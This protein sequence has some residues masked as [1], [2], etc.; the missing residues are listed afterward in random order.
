MP[1]ARGVELEIVF[2]TLNAAEAQ[3]IRSRLDAAGYQPVL[4]PEIDPLTISGFTVPEGGI[5]I[6]VP[7]EH[8]ASARALLAEERGGE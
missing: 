6:R 1:H 7:A 3:L 5:K 2:E 8:A 4:D